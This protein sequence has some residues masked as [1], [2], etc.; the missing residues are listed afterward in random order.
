[1]YYDIVATSYRALA[2]LALSAV[3]AIPLGMIFGR[4]PALYDFVELPVD[5]FRSVPSSSLFFL[6]ILI[7]GIGEVSKL[8]VVFYGCVLILLVNTV[9][10]AKATKDKQD[11]INMLRSFGAT[12]FQIY[13]LAVFRDALP[14]VS[15]GFRVCASL[16]FVLV[17][18]TEMFLSATAGLGRRIY[19]FYLAYR[20]PEMYAVIIILGLLGFTVNR[21]FLALERRICFW[22]PS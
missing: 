21:A 9:Y 22:L 1:M 7:F 16:S 14:H 19:D 10:G 12:P 6:F 5:F 18:V 11:R 2:G 15:A 8:A 17:V 20:V 3:I 13:R 4:V